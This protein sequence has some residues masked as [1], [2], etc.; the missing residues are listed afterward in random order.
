MQEILQQ[1]NIKAILFDLDDTLLETHSI[2]VACARLLITRFSEL[3]GVDYAEIERAWDEFKMQSREIHYVNPTPHWTCVMQLFGE[4]YS[5]I[6]ENVQAESLKTI[7][8]EIYEKAIP[9]K[10]GA[11]EL[12]NALQAA[13]VEIAI[14]TN[15]A[16]EWTEF[17]MLEAGINQ[18]VQ[19]N[20]L[21][22]VE[23]HIK[24]SREHWE[25][26]LQSMGIAPANALIVGDNFRADIMPAI[27]LGVLAVYFNGEGNW[28]AHAMD[29]NSGDRS[30]VIEINHLNNLIQ[31]L[32][33]WCEMQENIMPNVK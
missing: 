13:G 33:K 10:E 28:S 17:K 5:L 24:K 27:D 7:Q 32:K 15:A 9:L 20:R 18:F 2:F 21:F 1:L 25:A 8:L 31:S 12:L 11:F 22:I 19:L 3:T 29:S 6:D 14:V 26:A 4:R 30:R 16:Q 23:P